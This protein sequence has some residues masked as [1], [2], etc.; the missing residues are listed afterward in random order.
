MNNSSPVCQLNNIFSLSQ[1]EV[2]K[3]ISERFYYA[4][5]SFF[6]DRF[7]FSRYAKAVEAIFR[8]IHGEGKNI[9][10][11]G[12]GFGMMSIILSSL[13]A[14]KVYSIDFS[15][16][17]TTGFKK[18]LSKLPPIDNLEVKVMD[19]E[20]T[21]FPDN[22]FDVIVASDSISHIN[23]LENFFKEA[24]RIL[25]NKGTF[26][27]Y[28]S[29]NSFNIQ[30]RFFLHKYWKI[31]ECGPVDPRLKMKKPFSVMRKEMI[32]SHAPGISLAKLDFLVKVTRGMNEK[33]IKN[34]VD[35][36]LET[37]K[38][39]RKVGF[40]YVDPHSG[41]LAEKSINPFGL[42]KTLIR[43][44]FQARVLPPYFYYTYPFLTHP[45]KNNRYGDM[46]RFIVKKIIRY[47]YPLS[48]LTTPR[49]ELLAKN[50]KNEKT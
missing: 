40:P 38:I 11:A 27:L 44:G 37:G 42:K 39:K 34:A 43:F 7:K 35:K 10:D 4:F 46:M 47:T 45:L 13:G 33:E 26:Y 21:E 5:E 8:L 36:Y 41:M 23:N 48:L 18:I 6:Q 30:H 1:E 15:D 24:R 28:E 50:E 14:K 22:F 12:C 49:F 29:N 25:K 3:E 16:I 32:L 2:E 20:R 19:C 9:L 31:M 17:E